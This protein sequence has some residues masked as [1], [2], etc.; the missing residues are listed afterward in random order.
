MVRKP[1]TLEELARVRIL[2][3]FWNTAPNGVDT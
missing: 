2:K 1:E 3:G